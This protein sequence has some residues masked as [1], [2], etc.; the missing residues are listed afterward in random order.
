MA[1]EGWTQKEYFYSV[2]HG[3]MEQTDRR[4]VLF[5]PGKFNQMVLR[6]NLNFYAN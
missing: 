1:P 2:L 5:E 6:N 3:P 4:M